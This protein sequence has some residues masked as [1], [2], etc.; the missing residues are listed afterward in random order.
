[1][2]VDARIL[3]GPSLTYEKEFGSVKDGSWNL[4]NGVRFHKCGRI[5]SYGIASFAPEQRYGGPGPE[6]LQVNPNSQLPLDPRLDSQE[7]APL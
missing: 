3:D 4:R 6:G 5:V 1:M 7:L 2:Q